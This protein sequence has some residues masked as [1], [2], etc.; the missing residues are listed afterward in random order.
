M[1]SIIFT[2]FNIC[3]YSG[4]LRAFYIIKI[5]I[6]IA[7]ILVPIIIIIKTSTSLFKVVTDGKTE[8]MRSILIQSLKNIF[9]GLIIFF[10]PSLINFT[11]SS[12]VNYTGTELL[13]CYTNATIDKI[14]ELEQIF[15]K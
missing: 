4:T 11:F 6:K 2:L 5:F 7:S 1:R 12:L 13:A 9:A 15:S 10:L 3:E 8:S 14:K